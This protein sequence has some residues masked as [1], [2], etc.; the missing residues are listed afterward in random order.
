MYSSRVFFAPDACPRRTVD[1][2]DIDRL[3]LRYLCAEDAEFIRVLLN[4]PV[5]LQGIRDKAVRNA[6]D[7]CHYILTGPVASYQGFGLCL[8]VLR[9]TIHLQGQEGETGLYVVGGEGVSRK[10]CKA[11][12]VP[13]GFGE[14]LSVCRPCLSSSRRP[15]VSNL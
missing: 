7:A 10:S 15:L 2:L 3:S 12:E 4:E 13:R 5:F 1:I 9:V 11:G 6:A 8:V 14:I